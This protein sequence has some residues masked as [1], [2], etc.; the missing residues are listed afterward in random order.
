ME[1]RSRPISSIGFAFEA[2]GPPLSCL[3]NMG[4]KQHRTHKTKNETAEEGAA[5][6][7]KNKGRK[8][9]GKN[10]RRDK[11]RRRTSADSRS[12][13]SS[14]LSRKSITYEAVRPLDSAAS[15][16]WRDSRTPSAAT[17]STRADRTAPPTNY[18]IGNPRRRG[19]DRPGM[20]VSRRNSTPPSV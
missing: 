15:A 10:G 4:G 17:V 18:A 6:F 1:F 8:M 9:P 2:A 3:W 12:R 14:P 5:P 16:S 19:S 13:N 7:F 20:V 11:L